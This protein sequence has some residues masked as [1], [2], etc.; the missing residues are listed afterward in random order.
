MNKIKHTSLT[1]AAAVVIALDSGAACA[2]GQNNFS[3]IGR[4][5]TESIRDLPSLVGASAYLI[6][7]L[8]GVT[9]ILKIRD[10]VESP[11]Q[12]PLKDGAI[13]LL[14]G[15]GLFALPMVFDAMRT[16]IGQGDGLGFL[17]ATLAPL[18]TNGSG[19]GG[20]AWGTAAGGSVGCTSSLNC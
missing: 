10:H 3:A 9:G 6:G 18:E 12:T 11:R 1:L 5:I 17:Q 20:G 15:G 14:A 16:T 4:N 2:A 13:R 19:G 8:L 7:I